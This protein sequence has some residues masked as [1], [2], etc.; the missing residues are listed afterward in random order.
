MEVGLGVKEEKGV[1]VIEVV[2]VGLGVCVAVGASPWAGGAGG[3]AS[4][5]MLAPTTGDLFPFSRTF[6]ERVRAP[7]GV[8]VRTSPK[9]RRKKKS[10]V[11]NFKSPFSG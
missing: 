9:Q 6:P 1:S 7:A 4:K 10:L 8:A 11:F 3:T 5:R 2:G